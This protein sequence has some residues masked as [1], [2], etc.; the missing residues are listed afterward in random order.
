MK[1]NLS[2]VSSYDF[3]QIKDYITYSNA[4]DV[5]EA[6]A[7][8]YTIVSLLPEDASETGFDIFKLPDNATKEEGS[9]ALKKGVG[10]LNILAASKLLNGGWRMTMDLTNYQDLKI[11]YTDLTSPSIE[12]AI[13]QAIQTQGFDGDDSEMTKEGVDESGNTYKSGTI[14]IDGETYFWRVSALKFNDAY[15]IQGMP[16][17][18]LYVGVRMTN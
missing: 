7:S 12:S 4:L 6:M 3:P 13:L 1:K 9:A 2:H 11:R 8:D 15:S 18:A 16:D 14:E 17:T 10:S 5:Y